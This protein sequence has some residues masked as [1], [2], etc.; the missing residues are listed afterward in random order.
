VEGFKIAIVVGGTNI[1]NQ[2]SEMKGGVEVVVATP[3]QFINHF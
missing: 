2:M 1:Y 3:S